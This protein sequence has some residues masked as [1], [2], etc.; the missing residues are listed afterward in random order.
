MFF[1]KT[2]SAFVA[3][4]TRA[5]A[6]NVWINF[7]IF[8]IILNFHNNIHWRYRSMRW[9]SQEA[10]S[11]NVNNAILVFFFVKHTIKQT[12]RFAI[13]YMYV[14]RCTGPDPVADCKCAETLQQVCSVLFDIRYSYFN[15][16]NQTKVDGACVPRTEMP[17]VFFC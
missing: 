2:N 14:F 11:C 5:S 6:L 9:V 8:S 16:S 7:V 15:L 12:L 1:S 3:T 4:F 10:D 13:L 17:V